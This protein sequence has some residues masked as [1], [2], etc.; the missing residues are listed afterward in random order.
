MTDVIITEFASIPLALTREEFD[1]ARQRAA[2]LLGQPPQTASPD[3]ELID[4][5]ELAARLH[6]SER[7]IADLTRAGILPHH[8]IGERAVR[9]DAAAVM[10]HTRF[11]G[12]AVPSSD[13]AAT[14]QRAVG[15]RK[16]MNR[17]AEIDA[18][19]GKSPRM[20]S[21]AAAEPEPRCGR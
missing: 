4:A 21:R 13:A 14:D 10:N 15:A 11:S 7:L 2:E 3:A 6:V 12:V 9:Y 1:T 20:F 5:A 16:P 8:R 17:L 18:V 19:S